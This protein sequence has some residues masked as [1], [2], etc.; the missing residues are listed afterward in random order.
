MQRPAGPSHPGQHLLETFLLH[1]L[2]HIPTL[3]Y[4]LVLMA[5]LTR[6]RN[7]HVITLSRTT[8][9]LILESGSTMK[10]Y[11]EGIQLLTL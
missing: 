3:H 9:A 2:P 10:I 6:Q 5:H 11:A 4:G 7:R 8:S 1:I